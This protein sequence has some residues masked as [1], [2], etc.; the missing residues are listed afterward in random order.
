MLSEDSS[1]GN[2][3]SLEYIMITASWGLA[4]Y[5]L[6]DR[7]RPAASDRVDSPPHLLH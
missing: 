3:E 1:W 4:P 6:V 5:V 2:V 7:N